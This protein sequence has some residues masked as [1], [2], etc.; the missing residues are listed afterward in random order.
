M[1]VLQVWLLPSKNTR[2]KDTTSR[3]LS[4]NS[5]EQSGNL[6]R[7]QEATRTTIQA[8][9]R[10]LN[11][12]KAQLAVAESCTGGLIAHLLTNVPG[13]SAW[14]LGGVTAY[15]NAVKINILGVPAEIIAAHGAVSAEVVLGM[16]HGARDLL[17][18][19]MALA[20]SG[21]A[22]P[23]G[24]TLEKP[25]GTVWVAWIVQETA[26]SERFLFPG[27]RLQIKKQ[28]AGAALA[29]MLRLLTLRP[30]LQSLL[31]LGVQHPGHG[32]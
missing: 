18:A 16:A 4:M 20:V 2:S 19:D 25:V 27:T 14:F 32:L 6:R 13:S 10:E 11:R 17:K 29:G 28:A 22:G 8:L 5:T 9:A 24:G 31:P 15:A 26:R 7:G 12:H 21:I 23:G 30:R 1:I 3:G